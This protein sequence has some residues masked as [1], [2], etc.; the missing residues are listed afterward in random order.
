MEIEQWDAIIVGGGSAGLSAALALV[1]ARRRV[2]VLDAGAPRNGVAAHMHGVLG[3]DGWSP[4]TLL[5]T[6]RGEVR[7]YG[8]E[9]RSAEVTGAVKSDEG[10]VVSLSDGGRHRGRRMLVATG[11]R[12]EMPDIP[13]L[14]QHWGTSAVVCPY[15]DGWEVRDQRIAVLLTEPM[16]AQQ[17]QL[18][19]QWSPRVTFITDGQDVPDEIRREL[20]A[21]GI[22][23]EDR[24][25]A[26]VVTDD[27]GGLQAI[28]FTDGTLIDINSIFFRSGVRPNDDLL[29]R[30]GAVRDEGPD[31]AW[32][33]VD[34]TGLTSVP[35]LWA[36]GN[37]VS[38]SANVPVSMASGSVAGAT[39]NGD[40]IKEEIRAALAQAG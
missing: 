37:V 36:V 38:S 6:G 1:R 8:G 5:E 4:L 15:C 12:D 10:F 2:L 35:G 18:L 40:L 3:R 19:R 20:V 25:V 17:A 24:A 28:R 23:V 27:T 16:S 21:R 30:L 9:V 22:V 14:A 11:L 26:G 34:A 31:G 13:G 39:I 29:V 32:V 33:R 7:S